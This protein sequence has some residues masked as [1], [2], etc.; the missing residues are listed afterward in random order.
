MKQI[1]IPGATSN[2]L[3]VK[4]LDSSS[5]VGAGLTGLTFS[6]TGLIISTICDNEASPTVYTQAGSTIEAVTTLGTFAAPT[7]TK[8]RIKE[9]DSTNHKG[10]Y[11]IQFA[12]ARFNVVSSRSMLISILGAT[13]LAQYDAEIALGGLLTTTA[14]QNLN[15]AYNGTGYTDG[16]A[17]AGSSTTITLTAGSSAT[18][19]FYNGFL[20]QPVGGT[21]GGQAPRLCVGYVGSTKVATVS[22]AWTTTP[23]STTTYSFIPAADWLRAITVE[24]VGSYTA[25]Q[26]LSVLLAGIAGGWTANGTFKTPDGST[27]RIAG[28]AA[29]SAPFRSSITLTPSS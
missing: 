8:C 24:S 4:L 7:A 14:A 19:S 9:L 6:S 5:T 23:D 15:N 17:Q 27:T 12:D 16:T 29:S 3:R 22:P 11:E 21:G 10:G 26:A 20:I 18:N 13:N 25:Q 1:I 2:I 28:T